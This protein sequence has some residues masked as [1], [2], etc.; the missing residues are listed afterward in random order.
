MIKK[1]KVLDLKFQFPCTL[2]DANYSQWEADM[3]FSATNG[4]V[5]VA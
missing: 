3:S 2:E 4:E 5:N 1:E